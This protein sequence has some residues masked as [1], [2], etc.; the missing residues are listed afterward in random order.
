MDYEGLL[1]LAEKRRSVRSFKPDPVP[2]EY[3]DNII[4]VARRAPSAANSQ[5]WEFVV[6]RKEEL[7][8]QIAEFV[9]EDRAL[10]RKM[11]LARDP[12]LRFP[13]QTSTVDRFGFEDAPVFIILLGDTRATEAFPIHVIMQRRQ[14]NLDSSLASAFLYMQL[15]ATALGL[16]AQW[17][18]ATRNHYAQTM[19]KSLLR[20]PEEMQIYDTMALGYPA[21]ETAPRLVRAKEE[22]V[23]QDYYDQAKFRTEEKIKEFIVALR[24]YQVR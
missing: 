20:I 22:M 24:Q 7:R 17:V 16:G 5:P 3:I 15:A 19:I 14:S 9:K 18:S 8:H 23:H 2:D 6:V 4:E 13:G 11:E 10:T 12:A 21:A 1:E